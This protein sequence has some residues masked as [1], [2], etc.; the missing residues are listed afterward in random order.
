MHVLHNAI[1]FIMAYP[2]GQITFPASFSSC[3][4]V[5]A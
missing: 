3:H 4:I 5:E 2:N 1:I